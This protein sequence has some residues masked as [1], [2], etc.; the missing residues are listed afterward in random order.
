MAGA[1]MQFTSLDLLYEVCFQYV[2]DAEFGSYAVW[3]N[4]MFLIFF[5]YSLLH[6][7]CCLAPVAFFLNM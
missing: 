3:Y 1:D 4:I 7:I 2:P 6:I 5:F